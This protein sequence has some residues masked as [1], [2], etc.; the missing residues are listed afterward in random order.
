MKKAWLLFCIFAIL[1]VHF[2][3]AFPLNMTVDSWAAGTY[4]VGKYVNIA[5][6]STPYGDGVSV[7]TIGYPGAYE[8]N[9]DF[10]GYSKDILIVPPSGTIQVS[11][12]FKYADVTPHPERK[13]MAMYLLR[14][15]LNGY[16]CNA[17]CILNYT[18]GDQPNTWYYRTLQVSGLP[19][20]QEFFLGFGRSDLCDMD[21]GLEASWAAVEVVSCRVL[22]VPSGYSTIQQALAAAV[23]G[24]TVLVEAGFYPE[25]VVVSQDF[26]K[27]VGE[28]CSTTVI[29]ADSSGGFD[30]AVRITGRNVSLSG[31]TLR[32]CFDSYG[33]AVFGEYTKITECFIMNNTVG[34]GVF[35]SNLTF[36]KN[37]VCNNSQGMW[38]QS[39]A[40]NCTFYHNSFC[41]N[42]VHV[43]QEPIQNAGLWDNGYAGNFWSNYSGVD[44]NG[45][46]IGDTSHVINAYNVDRYPLM[47][48]YLVGDVNHDGCVNM[49]DLW[50]VAKAYGSVPRTPN[51]NP[52][53]DMD[54]NNMINMLDLYK[55]AKQYGQR[56]P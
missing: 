27:L 4:P 24:D 36:T 10:F 33:V 18:M 13:Y 55:T 52:H 40:Q 19:P 35:A 3:E 20:G 22:K 50:L 38:L 6:V 7:N 32:N 8:W 28:N 48:M 9:Y 53:C 31:F 21:R 17:V 25:R 34:V 44:A 51:W 37:R 47:S 26:L 39:D 14:S 41:N 45:D 15:D 29:E 43:F 2:A 42:T 12:W 30:A 23:A 56:N 16:L 49:V 54:E 46:G 5:A 1:A 11:G